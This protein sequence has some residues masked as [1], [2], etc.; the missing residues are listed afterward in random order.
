MYIYIY[1]IS[2]VPPLIGTVETKFSRPGSPRFYVIM[3]KD[4]DGLDPFELLDFI[5]GNQEVRPDDGAGA[6]PLHLGG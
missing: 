5:Q 6:E 4:N 2:T 3:D 1:Y